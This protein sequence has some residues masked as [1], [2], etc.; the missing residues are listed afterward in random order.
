[1]SC[2]K[3]N[4]GPSLDVA[5][6]ILQVAADELVGEG[7]ELTLREGFTL[8]R[9]FCDQ[10]CIKVFGEPVEPPRGLDEISES[11]RAMI[12]ERACKQREEARAAESEKY[13]NPA[14]NP[15]IKTED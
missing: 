13:T 8:T 3:E 9:M 7:N 10:N 1:M 11:E 15:L 6:G 5:A 12:L 2:K 14:T 4:A